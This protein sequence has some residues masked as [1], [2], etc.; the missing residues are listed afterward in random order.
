MPNN[1][2]ENLEETLREIVEGRQLAIMLLGDS[3]K[4]PYNWIQ[5]MIRCYGITPQTVSIGVL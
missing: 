2:D 1:P 4:K 5:I 3:M